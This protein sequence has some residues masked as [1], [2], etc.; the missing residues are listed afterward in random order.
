MM[1]FILISS[2][3]ALAVLGNGC[4]SSLETTAYP[5]RIRLDETNLQLLAGC[6]EY[7]GQSIRLFSRFRSVLDERLLGSFGDCVMPLDTVHGEPTTICLT[8][9]SNRNILAT[10][11]L[12]GTPVGSRLFSG[13][14]NDDGYF[15]I[16]G[17]YWFSGIP[18][19]YSKTESGAAQLGLDKHHNLYIDIA[20]DWSVGVFILIGA[21]G[22]SSSLKD[23]YYLKPVGNEN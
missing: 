1:Q 18:P 16:S 4:G 10:A 14:I 5:H 13:E 15:R 2:I 6:Y 21:A 8:V 12:N 22:H 11:Y 9:D 20:F 23:T 17:Y 19:F 3:L 7:T